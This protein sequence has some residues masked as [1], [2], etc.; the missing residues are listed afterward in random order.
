MQEWPES[1]L[2]RFCELHPRLKGKF[3]PEVTHD[4]GLIFSWVQTR[5]LRLCCDHHKMSYF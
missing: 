2:F 3:T 5:G 1:H 4:L